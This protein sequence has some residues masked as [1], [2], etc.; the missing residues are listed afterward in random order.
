MAVVWSHPTFVTTRGVEP[1][2]RDRFQTADFI[3]YTLTGEDVANFP[4]FPLH[5]VALKFYEDVDM[6]VLLMDANGLKSP[7]AWKVGDTIKV[8]R[9]VVRAERLA[10]AVAF[11]R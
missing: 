10:I 2:L 6:W 3:S 4:N 11:Q 5:S 7:W 1:A 8:P 9:D